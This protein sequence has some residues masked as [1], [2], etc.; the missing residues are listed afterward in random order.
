MT[1]LQLP[2]LL[3]PQ[4][5]APQAGR[6]DDEDNTAEH[7]PEIQEHLESAVGRVP[8]PES[9]TSDTVQSRSAPS[10]PPSR[11]PKPDVEMKYASPLPSMPSQ[12]TTQLGS[13]EARSRQDIV[14]EGEDRSEVEQPILPVSRKRDGEE[15]STLVPAGISNIEN[16]LKSGMDAIGKS[17]ES[18]A[19]PRRKQQKTTHTTTEEVGDADVRN[20]NA[21]AEGG[22]VDDKNK[23]VRGGAPTRRYLNEL[24][25]PALLDGVKLVAR[26]QPENPLEVLG[27]YLIERSKTASKKSKSSGSQ[28]SSK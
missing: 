5:P 9:M 15:F 13:M 12:D 26:E 16:V 3:A 17:R 2:D 14:E 21:A 22:G 19:E 10:I 24:I 25:T 4:S 1:G 27:K 7:G 6:Q 28:K 8:V 11:S 23:P 18:S 20:G